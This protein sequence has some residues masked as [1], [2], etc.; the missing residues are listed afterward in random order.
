MIIFQIIIPCG[1][2]LSKSFV[3]CRADIE[4]KQKKTDP[5]YVPDIVVWFGSEFETSFSRSD[6]K[7]S[8]HYDAHYRFMNCR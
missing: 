8:K 5:E 1:I 6:I 7:T 4:K 2:N 3:A